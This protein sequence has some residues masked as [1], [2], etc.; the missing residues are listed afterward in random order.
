M[1]QDDTSQ[2]S[3]YSG[4]HIPVDSPSLPPNLARGNTGATSMC[5]EFL[6]RFLSIWW[7]PG[8][9][10]DFSGRVQSLASFCGIAYDKEA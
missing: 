7:V 10:P 2:K 9:K 3:Q 4:L 6:N 8:L 5:P 1:F